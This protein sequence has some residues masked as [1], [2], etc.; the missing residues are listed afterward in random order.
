MPEP[1]LRA[2][3]RVVELAREQLFVRHEGVP[4]VY[5]GQWAHPLPG[6]APD[7]GVA[8]RLAGKGSGRGTIERGGG[9]RGRETNG[10]S[11]GH[12]SRGR[13]KEGGGTTER[14]V[15]GSVAWS[16]ACVL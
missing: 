9:E 6:E 16:V 10:L 4:G 1:R 3:A 15:K 7:G 12:T 5:S 14:G 11:R 2:P 8:V 13:V